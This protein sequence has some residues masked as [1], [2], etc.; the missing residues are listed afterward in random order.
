MPVPEWTITP[1]Q[2]S[3]LRQRL[4]EHFSQEE[5]Q[6][7]CF[8]LGVRFDDLAGQTISAKAQSL[9][10]HLAHRGRVPDLIDL[11]KQLRLDVD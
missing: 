11:V 4:V 5:L 2:L 9:L 8:E 1:H 10:E 6:Q 3:Q 7:L